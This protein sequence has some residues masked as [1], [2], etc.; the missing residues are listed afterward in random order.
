MEAITL[1][2]QQLQSAHQWFEGTMAD[3]T[4][5]Q[6]DWLPPGN[7]N[8]LGASYMHVIAS[9]DMIVQGMLRQAAPLMMTTWAGRTGASIPQ[10]APGPDWTHYSTWTHNVHVDLGQA[11]EYAQA[12]Y[13]ASADYL[14]SLKSA[15][16]DREMDL[17]GVG[18][19]KANLGWVIA[20]LMIGHC[21][22]LMGEISVLKG[23]QGAKGYP[24]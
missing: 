6:M 8:P 14:A 5:E 23:I 16:L 3:V 18:M 19:G 7:A 10:P 22:D 17:S 21:H 1:L 12:V 11:R 13:T 20:N 2:R 4:Q 15:D 24:F 9:E